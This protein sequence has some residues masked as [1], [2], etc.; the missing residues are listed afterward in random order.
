M[1]VVP[2]LVFG[3][4]ILFQSPSQSYLG[5]KAQTFASLFGM[6]GRLVDFLQVVPWKKTQK[7]S[8]YNM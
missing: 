7:T 2:I 3:G 4:A 6:T 8:I 5:N 1:V